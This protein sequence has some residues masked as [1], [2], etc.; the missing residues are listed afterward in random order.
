MSSQK[1]KL[2]EFMKKQ[3][4]NENEIVRSVT[5][6]I[7][8]INNPPVKA[9][10][11]GISLDSTKHAELYASAVTLL[12]TV[13][14]AMTQENLDQQRALVEKHIRLE[15]ELIKKLEDELPTIENK[16][17]AFLL[18]SI[19]MDERRHHAMLKQV[20]EIIVRGET[21]TEEDW[22]KFLWE[23]SPFHGAPGG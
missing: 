7:K 16:K 1:E 11:K 12:E 10:L 3:I 18:N 4:Q 14:Q 9:V 2:V 23:E 6:G 8:N 22:W 21:I 13:S 20:L 15:A 19:L 5:E 17:V